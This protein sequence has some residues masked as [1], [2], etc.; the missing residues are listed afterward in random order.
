LDGGASTT[1]ATGSGVFGVAADAA[2][3]YWAEMANGTIMKVPVGG[4]AATTV[5][6]G[7]SGPNQI[8]IDAKNLYVTTGTQN[9]SATGTIARIAKDGSA[10]TFLA[11]GL[12]MPSGIAVD[13]T[14][15]YWTTLGD[16]HSKSGA[17]MKASPK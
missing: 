12:M 14:S 15:V 10:V 11:M 1:L 2:N 17:I 7:L 4:G 3:V 6:S 8:A 16:G 5:A 13:A 9:S